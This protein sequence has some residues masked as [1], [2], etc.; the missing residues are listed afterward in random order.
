MAGKK[1]FGFQVSG[2]RFQRVGSG[3]HR[4]T[5]KPVI[6]LEDFASRKLQSAADIEAADVLCRIAAMISKYALYL[7]AK[8]GVIE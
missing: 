8:R 3:S 1:G 7:E 2:F 6:R 5:L 4:L